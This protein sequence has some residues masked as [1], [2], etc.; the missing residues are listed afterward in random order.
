MKALVPLI[1]LAAL[2]GCA[3]PHQF[4]SPDASWR[5]RSGQA[6]YSSGDTTLVGETLLATRGE[7]DFV[8]DFRKGPGIPLLTLQSDGAVTRYSGLLAR[9]GWESAVGAEVPPH[10]RVWQ[11]A[12]TALAGHYPDPLHVAEGVAT[13]DFLFSR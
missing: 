11:R 10:L 9:R 5:T 3:A 7:K 4:A 2:A 6:K 8:L 1:S 12:R 13:V